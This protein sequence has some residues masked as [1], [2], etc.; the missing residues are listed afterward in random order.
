MAGR[1][2]NAPMF[3]HARG[4]KP[5]PPSALRCANGYLTLPPCPGIR[6]ARGP[7][8]PGRPNDDAVPDDPD[9]SLPSQ[10]HCYC[11]PRQ[12]PSP[13]GT[14][15]RSLGP[16]RTHPARPA[17]SSQ[18]PSPRRFGQGSGHAC[19]TQHGRKSIPVRPP[20]T[21]LAQFFPQ[22]EPDHACTESRPSPTFREAARTWPRDSTW[23]LLAGAA[24]S[25][26]MAWGRP[27]RTLSSTRL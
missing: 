21:V 22:G 10:K 4:P 13:P 15:P 9:A 18:D 12:M 23:R 17:L 26:A 25:S 7:A 11:R 8:S 27:I 24:R 6:L 1:W 14:N 2:P 20:E 3:Q 19:P 5:R 16:L